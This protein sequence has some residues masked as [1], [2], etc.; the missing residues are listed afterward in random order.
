MIEKKR[1]ASDMRKQLSMDAQ[2]KEFYHQESF[3]LE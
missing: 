1:T 3:D 2:E